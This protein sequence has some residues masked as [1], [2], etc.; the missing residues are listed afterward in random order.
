MRHRL[1]QL[2]RSRERGQTKLPVQREVRHAD[3]AGEKCANA[4]A[5]L[6]LE[7]R[8]DRLG[9]LP[10]RVEL[11]SH[12]MH[13]TVAV[14]ALPDE[15]PHRLAIRALTAKIF[16]L[17][18]NRDAKQ[19]VLN[20]AIDVMCERE[21]KSALAGRKDRRLRIGILKPHRDAIGIDDGLAT[22]ERQ[23]GNEDLP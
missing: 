22:I 13:E 16:Q 5:E 20:R 15:P 19:R 21:L 4:R 6:L 17:V 7:W 18:R 11:A 2:Q 12:T 1:R 8:K 9:E 10:I 14:L 23:C 3:A